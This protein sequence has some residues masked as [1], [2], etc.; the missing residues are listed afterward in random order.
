MVTLASSFAD[1]HRI[2]AWRG[3]SRLCRLLAVR[4]EGANHQWRKIP[5]RKLS[6]DLE[7]DERLGW[8]TGTCPDA[9]PARRRHRTDTLAALRLLAATALPIACDRQQMTQSLFFFPETGRF[10]RKTGRRLST[11]GQSLRGIRDLDDFSK[12]K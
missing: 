11:N 9:S 3:I 7:A 12:S 5:P 8:V 1:S 4:P 10:S 2:H 6:I